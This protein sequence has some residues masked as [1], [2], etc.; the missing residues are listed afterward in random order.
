MSFAFAP[1]IPSF[2]A[3]AEDRSLSGEGSTLRK[4]LEAAVSPVGDRGDEIYLLVAAALE[5]ARQ[6]DHVL[7]VPETFGRALD[8]L[9][10]L[11]RQV[12]LP[13]VVVESANEI[14]MDWDEGHRRVLSLTVRD[15]PEV[16]FAGLFGAEPVHGRV[17][18]VEEIP[19]TLRFFIGKLYPTIRS[20]RA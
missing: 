2:C 7:V 18:F 13:D 16:G 8:L 10:R 5:K 3:L 1:T 12:P 6:Q 14:G 9:D 11:P 4:S 15:T 20:R 19:E 17:V